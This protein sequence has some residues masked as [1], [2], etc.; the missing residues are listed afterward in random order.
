MPDPVSNSFD[1][2]PVKE[3]DCFVLDPASC[4]AK[5]LGLSR[6]DSSRLVILEPRSE[7]GGRRLLCRTR[8]TDFDDASIRYVVHDLGQLYLDVSGKPSIDD[9]AADVVQAAVTPECRACGEQQT[10]VLCYRPLEHQPFLDDQQWV[11]DWIRGLEGRV[12]DVGM[13]KLPYID[14]LADRLLAGTVE[15]WGLDPDE[16]AIEAARSRGLPIEVLP[17]RV[18]DL[19]GD[20]EPFDA[21]LAIR[22]LNHFDDPDAAMARMTARL[23]DG[24]RL[25]LVESAPLPLVRGPAHSSFSH[26]VSDGGFQHLRNWDSWTLL[27]AVRGRLP[28]AVRYHRPIGRD[29]CDQW[30]LVIEKAAASVSRGR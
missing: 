30:I 15:Y 6:L 24:G 13:G 11:R 3:L 17:G 5:K 23:R 25:L 27:S 9:F 22:S 14:E 4:S 10:C 19:P 21:V 12:L 2:V 26:E 28:L 20:G 29:T 7:P 8:T 18:E 16:R 1:Y